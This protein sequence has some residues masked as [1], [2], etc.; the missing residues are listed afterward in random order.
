MGGRAGA[1]LIPAEGS[2]GIQ[3]RNGGARLG[4]GQIG[5]AG[6]DSREILRAPIRSMASMF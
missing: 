1:S 5:A 2:F 4:F 3:L 6:A